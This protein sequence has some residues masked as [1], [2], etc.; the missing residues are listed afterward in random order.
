MLFLILTKVKEENGPKLHMHSAALMK[1]LKG[2]D[3]GQSIP[4]SAHTQAASQKNF[5]V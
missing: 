4:H 5:M 2:F 3:L 1:V